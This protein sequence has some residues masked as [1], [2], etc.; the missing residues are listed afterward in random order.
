MRI[1]ISEMLQIIPISPVQRSVITFSIASHC[2]FTSVNLLKCLLAETPVL[3]PSSAEYAPS[4]ASVPPDDPTDGK[5][6][7]IVKTYAA[8]THTCFQ[9]LPDGSGIWSHHLYR[10]MQHRMSVHVIQDQSRRH[11]SPHPGPGSSTKLLLIPSSILSVPQ[12]QL[13]LFI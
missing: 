7:L 6:I 2:L 9:F 13:H 5:G 8:H 3:S 11:L 12:F 1:K 4:K 10:D